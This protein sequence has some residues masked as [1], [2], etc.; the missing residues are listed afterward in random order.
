MGILAAAAAALGLVAAAAGAAVPAEGSSAAP[1]ERQA[2][3]HVKPLPTFV[4]KWQDAKAAAADLVARGKAKPNEN[5]RVRLPNGVF[6]DY[7]TTGTD[8]IVTLL[9]EFTDPEQ[10]QIPQP[11]RSVDNTTYWSPDF[12]PQHYRD[13][14]FAPGG[15]SYGMPS[16]R[17]FYLQLSSGRYT[18]EGQVSEWVQVGQPESAYG[19][20]SEESGPGGDDLNGPVYRVVRDALLATASTNE[21]IN[22]DPAVV[23]VWDRYDCDGDGNFD[24]PDGYVDHFQ[25]VHAG[26]GEEAGGGAQGGDAIWSHRWYANMNE[27]EGPADC[28]L[29]GYPVPGTGLWVGDYTIEPEN[30]AVGVFAHEFAHDL[31]LPDLYDTAGGENGTGFWTLM[32]SGSWASNDP[33]AIDTKPVHMGA[34]EKLVLGWLEGDLALAALG[35]DKT[36]DLGPAEGNARHGDQALRVNLPDYEKTT[37][38]V[39]PEGSDPFY[40]YSGSGDNLDVR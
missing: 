22:W 36:V 24:E 28:Q 15:A 3:G 40:Y 34:W 19:A 21:N 35:D 10:G 11:D 27:D 14:L 6:V 8:H 39:A 5:G 37:T 9:A 26:E 30:G 4:E 23:D 16:M 33:N 12:S 32:S 31:G 7:E 38:I 25:I 1:G 29:G 17:D 2:R 18:V 13:L 20:N